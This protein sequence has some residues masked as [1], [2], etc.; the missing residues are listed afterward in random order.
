MRILD[1]IFLKF[2]LNF[3]MLT[4]IF[5]NLKTSKSKKS[6]TRFGC[7]ELPYFFKFMIIREKLIPHVFSCQGH[8]LTP[9]MGTPRSRFPLFAP[10]KNPWTRGRALSHII[11]KSW[12]GSSL[13]ALEA[14]VLNERGA[15]ASRI[16]KLLRESCF[17]SWLVAPRRGVLYERGL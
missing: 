13:V 17:R 12:F 3:E 10:H 8:I 7:Q 5:P 14:M 4:W 15:K 2:E 16:Y 6:K 11:N 1:K 9:K